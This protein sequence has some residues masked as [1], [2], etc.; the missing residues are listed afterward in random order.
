L[1][2]AWSTASSIDAAI[3]RSNSDEPPPVVATVR[4]PMANLPSELYPEP[5]VKWYPNAAEEDPSTWRETG[6]KLPGRSRKQ[7]PAPA[8]EAPAPKPPQGDL[9]VTVAAALVSPEAIEP[10]REEACAGWYSVSAYYP[11]EDLPVQESRRTQLVQSTRPRPRGREE[12][13][14]NQRIRVPFNTREQFLR[15]AVYRC[16]HHEPGNDCSADNITLVAE[17]TIPIADPAASSSSMWPLVR[18]FEQKGGVRLSVSMPGSG[19]AESPAAEEP[20]QPADGPASP[21]PSPPQE[22]QLQDVGRLAATA[23]VQFPPDDAVARASGSSSG[24][25]RDHSV[26]RHTCAGE[27][28]GLD[29]GSEV[30]VFSKTACKWQRGR[31]VE[32]K[33]YVLTAEYE[34]TATGE[35]ITRRRKFDLGAS[36]VHESLRIPGAHKAAPKEL[37]LRSPQPLRVPCQRPVATLPVEEPRILVTPPPKLGPEDTPPKDSEARQFTGLASSL[38]ARL[39]P[40][41]ACMLSS[42]E[43]AQEVVLTQVPVMA[44]GPVL[45][46]MW[47]ERTPSPRRQAAGM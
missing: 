44:D 12:C 1:W 24:H 33:D 6:L 14:L 27:C 4:P 37:Q 43:G 47:G 17:A 13:T 19:S 20:V 8:A 9:E 30:E 5:N 18:D 42:P 2:V 16:Q 25:S 36:N 26:G 40:W 41:S 29:V 11:N 39:S 15:V 21:A 31:V 45:P 10:F 22:E 46:Q 34:V 7:S 35:T 3:S 28:S 32:M 38:A 23:L